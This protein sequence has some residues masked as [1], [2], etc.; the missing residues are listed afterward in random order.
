MALLLILSVGPAM[1]ALAGEEED[2]I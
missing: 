1:W 2:A